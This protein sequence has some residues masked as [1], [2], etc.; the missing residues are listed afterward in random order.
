MTIRTCEACGFENAEPGKNCALCGASE[1]APAPGWSDIP[2]LE[3]TRT[4]GPSSGA[5]QMPPDALLG[6]VYGER[7]RV[8]A[9]LGAGGMGRV[10]RVHDLVDQ[11][12][13]ALKV[14]R[15]DQQGDPGRGDRFRR[16]VGILSRLSHP[17]VPRVVGFGEAG[18][19]LFF[20]SELVK[21]QDVKRLLEQRRVWTPTAA[22]ALA[23][24]VAEA[25]AAAHALGIVH[26]DVKPGN[27]MISP[28][29]RVHLLDFGLARGVGVDM[30][31]LTRTGTILG[32]PAYMSP[33]QFDAF[34]VDGRSDLYSL[35]VVLF[36]ILTGR[37]PF[38]GASLVSV[39]LK[40]KTE[41]P[42]LP[43][44]LRVEVPAW[45]ER[46]VLRCL[47]KDP[48][49]RFATAEELVAELRRPRKAG[50]PRWR[51]LPGGDKVMEDDDGS[52]DWALVL[53][54][55]REKTGWSEGMALRFGERYYR[56]TAINAASSRDE[57]WSYGFVAW[58][59]GEVFRRLV[60]YEEDRA[61]RAS[62]PRDASLGGRLK[63]FLSRDKS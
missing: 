13:R 59:Q 25:L 29:D 50:A 12:D 26:R 34:G 46:V 18:G 5:A 11:A 20:V 31:T 51:P 40:H 22:A 37:L 16:E 2:T 7:Y 49:R 6:R 52:S 55:V 23:A 62:P 32:T 39:A 60:D 43:R 33:E 3:L 41:P 17:A 45:L 35:G 4:S 38:K 53:A 19:E 48:T 61:A 24:T 27:I 10:Y 1:L 56:L 63:G 44:G 14:I 30:T 57:A 9:F 58:P 15:P 8:D 28:G 36:E 42:P 21:G 47:E 54:S